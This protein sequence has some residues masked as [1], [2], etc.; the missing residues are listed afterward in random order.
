M[1]P[2]DIQ[3]ARECIPS[4]L[5]ESL[6]G[7][8]LDD[9]IDIEEFDISPSPPPSYAD[10]IREPAFISPPPY[11]GYDVPSTSVN[12][13]FDE[14]ISITPSI[15]LPSF[16]SPFLVLPTRSDILNSIPSSNDI[17]FFLNEENQYLINIPNNFPLY[18]L[19]R[20]KYVDMIIGLFHYCN[21]PY[22]QI[23]GNAI[24][25][26]DRFCHT[27][28]GCTSHEP[29]FLIPYAHASLLVAIKNEILDRVP[30]TSILSKMNLCSHELIIASE[31]SLLSTLNY[32]IGNQSPINFLD[33][34]HFH[35]IANSPLEEASLRDVMTKASYFVTIMTL[36]NKFIYAKPSMCAAIAM[37]WARAITCGIKTWPD[38]MVYSSGGYTPMDL[39]Y[40]SGLFIEE[41]STDL[42]EFPHLNNV[43]ESIVGTVYRDFAREMME[44]G[45]SLTDVL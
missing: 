29:W 24:N 12:E 3:M 17:E 33:S 41:L 16:S 32:H 23:L 40:L 10:A 25:I 21:F 30:W 8:L 39:E 43:F 9:T 34:M 2:H 28:K 14:N 15:S 5:F 11:P 44:S 35:A 20:N 22:P 37:F 6:F 4:F 36:S 1:Y 7:L 42:D 18:I 13:T 31:R 45:I 27:P 19:Q 26:F 38:I